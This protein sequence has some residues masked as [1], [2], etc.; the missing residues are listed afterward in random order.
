MTLSSVKIAGRD[1]PSLLAVPMAARNPHWRFAS[2][3]DGVGVDR[4]Y[5]VG[6]FRNNDERPAVA[7]VRDS[8]M[9]ILVDDELC[10][11]TTL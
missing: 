11:M 1:I 9:E 3:G 10:I 8:M 4:R 2:S 7:I 5:G 6:V